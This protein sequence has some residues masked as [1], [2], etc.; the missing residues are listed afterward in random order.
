M[1]MQT[2]QHLERCFDRMKDDLCLPCYP[3]SATSRASAPLTGSR[4]NVCQL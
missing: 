1:A 4:S 3:G 2:A